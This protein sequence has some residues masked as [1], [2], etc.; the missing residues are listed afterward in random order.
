M[1]LLDVLT[2]VVVDSQSHLIPEDDLHS[3]PLDLI[4]TGFVST[5][6]LMTDLPA[7]GNHP[8]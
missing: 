3:L 7:R 2:Q 4:G 1:L 5:A 6:V 8:V